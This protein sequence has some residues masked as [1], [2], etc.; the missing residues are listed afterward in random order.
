MCG[1]IGYTGSAVAQPILMD[2]LRA[3][4]YRGY[5][6]AGIA[7]M[8]RGKLKTCKAE[9]RL[10]ALAAALPRKPFTGTTG[11]GHTRWATHGKPTDLN[12][13]PHNDSS[14]QIAVVHNGIIE[15]AASL[16][17]QLEQ[18]G[19]S[20]VSE[21]DTEVLAHLIA[22]A[23]AESL[24]GKVREVLQSVKGTYGLAVVDANEP[25]TIVAARNGSPVI[26]GFGE[27]EMFVASDMSA[28]TRHTREISHLDDGEIAC[29]TSTGVKV[30]TLDDAP[31]HKDTMTVE[32]SADSYDKDGHEHFML[33]EIYD[34]PATIKRTL[35]GRLDERFCTARLGGLNLEPREALDIDRVQLLGCGSAYYAGKAGADMIETLARIPAIAEPAAEF[36][37]RNPVIQPNTLYIVIS[38]SGETFDTLAAAREIS[39]KG[40]RV[41]GIIN[42]VGSTIAREV[43]GGIYMH[44]GPEA[45]VASTKAY[46]SMQVCFALLALHLARIRDLSP[47]QGEKLLQSLESLPDAITAALQAEAHIADI[48]RKYAAVNSMFFIGKASA[49]PTALEG[50]QK[51]KEIS[52]IH[53][54][55]YPAS[56]L[57][58]GP[59]AL[60]SPDTPTVVVLPDNDLL[61]KSLSSLEEIKARSGPAIVVTNS[62]DARIRDLADD[63]IKTPASHEL[64]HPVVMG[65]SLQLFAYHCARVLK[66]DIDRPRN[67]AKSVTVE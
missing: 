31:R 67:L 15:N 45:S 9:G 21:T 12:A 63:I 6:S 66:R 44:A 42:S 34:Q 48:A 61:E 55:A 54:E 43:D 38:Q 26:L 57:K 39:R 65:I 29:I 46:T 47:Q 59:L 10:A 60:I 37:Y 30:T 28:L 27:Q 1:I 2:G 40:G 51:L 53:A 20:L 14:Q 11:I 64:L 52:Y 16:R 56:E 4:E 17:S 19:I 3:L 18:Q 35:S 32:G 25:G 58:H 8:H 13:H 7:V 62:D 23:S 24:Q 49:F 33:R 41:L 5:D 50:A 36:R 22:S